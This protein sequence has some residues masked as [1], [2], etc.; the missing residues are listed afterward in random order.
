[1]AARSS[2][3]ARASGSVGGCCKAEAYS[4]AAVEKLRRAK[5]WSAATAAHAPH[6]HIITG[7]SP[8]T[9][10]RLGHTVA[11]QL[12]HFCE[13]M[14]QLTLPLCREPD[15][16]C[17]ADHPV[18]EHDCVVVDPQRQPGLERS[19]QTCADLRKIGQHHR[20]E[21]RHGDGQHLEEQHWRRRPASRA[22]PRPPR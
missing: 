19:A 22:A 8:V 14:V 21:W 1:M 12:E 11:L 17:F 5:R 9:G 3:L 10:E 2:M 18:P 7:L 15:A 6:A 4:A 20:G 13:Q 16:D